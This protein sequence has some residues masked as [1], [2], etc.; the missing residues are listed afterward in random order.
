[1]ITEVDCGILG[2]FTANE[3]LC[4]NF[5][6]ELL[7]IGLFAGYFNSALILFDD[8]GAPTIELGFIIEDVLLLEVKFYLVGTDE[9]N[10]WLF[11]FSILMRSQIAIILSICN[12]VI[13]DRSTLI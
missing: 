2:F 5:N 12:P 4:S 11:F 8:C 7:W 1:M 6:W 9:V 3:E 10:Y 13:L